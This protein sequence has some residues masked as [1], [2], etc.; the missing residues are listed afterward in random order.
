MNLMISACVGVAFIESMGRK[1][2]MAWGALAQAICFSLVA[3]G[4][5]ANQ[6]K[7]SIVAI[8]FVFGFY[9]VFGLTW[10]AIP[11][12]YPAE[13]DTQQWRNRGAGIATATNWTCNY[14][15]VLATPVGTTNISWRYY[16]VFAVLN[17]SFAPV[18]CW[19]YETAGRS[20]EEIDL[21]FERKYTKEPSMSPDD[22]HNEG[23]RKN[24][25]TTS[26]WVES[27]IDVA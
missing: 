18:V 24:T 14:A 2:L 7:W 22:G 27:T 12:I 25:E 3:G 10:L 11:W 5:G 1:R 23:E 4:L 26:E 20:L 9:T 17:V 6:D 13:V 15:V 16:I 19:F 8:S 21:C